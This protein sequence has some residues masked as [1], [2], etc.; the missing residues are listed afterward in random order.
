MGI[1]DLVNQ[2]KKL[3]EQNQDKIQ[4]ALKSEQA[5]Q[6]SDTILDGAAQAAKKVTGGKFDSQIDQA[7]DGADK[8]IGT[9]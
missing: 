3:F 1:E 4:A 7:R 8:A 2:G 5:E 9:D 6:I